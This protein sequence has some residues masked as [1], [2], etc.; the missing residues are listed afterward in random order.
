M[1]ELVKPQIDSATQLMD[2]AIAHLEAEL[3]KI[4]A[5]KASPAMLDGIYVDYYVQY[6]NT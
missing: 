1:N 5:G 2:K 6:S 3:A 4:R